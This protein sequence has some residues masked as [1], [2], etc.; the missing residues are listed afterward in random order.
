MI[1]HYG[2]SPQRPQKQGRVNMSNY[3]VG[4][5]FDQL[6]GYKSLQNDQL[7]KERRDQGADPPRRPQNDQGWLG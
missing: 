2:T 1:D 7:G 6:F 5:L 4:T 3:R